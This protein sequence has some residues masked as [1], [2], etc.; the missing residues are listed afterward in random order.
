ML[1]DR[2]DLF[3][4]KLGRRAMLRHARQ[5]A[6]S[7]VALVPARTSGDLRH[8]G[9]QQTAHADAVELGQPGKGDVI[10]IE[11]E[12][13]ADRV[14]RDDVVDLAALEERDLLVSRLKP[15][16][17]PPPH[18]R[19]S[20]TF[21]PPR[22]VRRRRRRSRCAGQPRKRAGRYASAWKNA[23]DRRFPP[24]TNWRPAVE[25]RGAQQHGLF[26]ATVEQSVGEDMA[27]SRSAPICASSSATNAAPAPPRGIARR[28]STC[29]AHPSVDL[30]PGNQRDRIVALD[31]PDAARPARAPRAL[32][33]PEGAAADHRCVTSQVRGC[34]DRATYR[35]RGI[36]AHARNHISSLASPCGTRIVAS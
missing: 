21:R 25:R 2:I 23:G 33:P 26:T 8:L 17:S 7:A 10:D 29:S 9:R 5:R 19:G 4:G 22:P 35:A 15:S 32:Q 27:G 13:H 6:E 28:C 24:G 18:C 36:Q 12:P 31:C 20:A 30:P 14:G 34:L 11:I 16:A 1:L 3:L